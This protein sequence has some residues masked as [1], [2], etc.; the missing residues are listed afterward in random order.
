MCVGTKSLMGW[1]LQ[2]VKTY[3]NQWQ[4]KPP[5]P[6]RVCSASGPLG[7]LGSVFRRLEAP[8]TAMADGKDHSMRAVVWF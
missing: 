8:V 2:A 4:R 6:E 7:R 3:G 1:K 5:N